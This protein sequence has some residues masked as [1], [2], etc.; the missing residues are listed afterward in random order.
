M[1]ESI[2]T[3]ELAERLNLIESMM[4]EGRRK[5]E[6]WSWTFLLWG[7]A[8][9]IAFFWGWLG[10]GRYAWPITMLA[11]GALTMF[12][13]ACRRASSP[14]T[15]LSRAI[16]SVWAATGSSLFIVLCSLGYSGRLSDANSMI[17]VFAAMLGLANAA[18]AL[19][20]RWKAQMFCAIIW[21]AAA[22]VAC[23][24]SGK[25]LL[26]DFLVAVFFGQI[27]FGFYGMY[28][29]SQRR[30]RSVAHV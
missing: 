18:S 21:W 13:I 5:V 12:I 30:R 8:Y 11:A 17:A 25:V 15:T 22:V 2:S 10:H 16:G 29:E 20:L 27:V 3:N 6:S 24:G 28:N 26:L 4:A 1:T 14:A 23:Y 7:V 19:T 9:Y